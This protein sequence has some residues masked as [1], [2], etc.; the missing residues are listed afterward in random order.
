MTNSTANQGGAFEQGGGIASY[1]SSTLT[2][3]VVRHNSA[4]NGGGIWQAPSP[5]VLNLVNSQIVDSAPS[6]CRPVGS[7]P[8]CTS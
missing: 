1:G 4:L 5:S 7:V 2:K 8:G 3:T 6:N